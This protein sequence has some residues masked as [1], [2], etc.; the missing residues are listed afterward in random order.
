MAEQPSQTKPVTQTADVPAGIT[1]TPASDI[2]NNNKK[3]EIQMADVDTQLLAG[4]HSD[5][6][7]EQTEHYAAT[8]LE[9]MKGFDRVN[10]DVL[11]TGWENTN[12][13]KDARFDI[14]SR[15]ASGT[16]E[17]L[18]AT[19]NA[20][21]VVTDRLWSLNR[22]IMDTRTQVAGLGYQVRDGFTAAAK[23]AE[24]NALKTQVALAQQSTYLSDR[25]DDN[26][27]NLT[28]LVTRIND[29]TLNRQLVE[30]AAEIVEERGHARHWRGHYDQ[31]QF[32][33][34]TSQLQAF[35]S[36][37]AETRQGMVNFGTMAGV[38][39]T[40]TANNVR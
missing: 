12:S 22:D 40:S 29:D 9:N 18:A 23:D 16:A 32:A 19:G 11:K 37:L 35:Q 7:R 6:R 27:K 10:A 26:Y 39:Q 36:Q 14:N 13:V 2:S 38:G 5:I 4:Q 33:S 17:N 28:S 3:E 24:I 20:K 31:A 1:D 25:A 21:D 34:L 15:I 8:Q 30:R